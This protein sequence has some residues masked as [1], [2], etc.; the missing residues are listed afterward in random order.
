[1]SDTALHVITSFLTPATRA[2]SGIAH[3]FNSGRLENALD[4][5]LAEDEG[6]IRISNR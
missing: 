3:S 6:G 4:Q 1:M 2:A 5:L